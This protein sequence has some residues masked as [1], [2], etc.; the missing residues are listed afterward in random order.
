[1][2]VDDTYDRFPFGVRLCGGNTDVRKISTGPDSGVGCQPGLGINSA[3]IRVS[4][5]FYCSGGERFF[6]ERDSEA[7]TAGVYDFNPDDGNAH[8][9]PCDASCGLTGIDG[10]LQFV[11]VRVYD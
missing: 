10:F 8:I 1:M 7:R 3:I 9:G 5:S 6:S 4:T 11:G 2:N